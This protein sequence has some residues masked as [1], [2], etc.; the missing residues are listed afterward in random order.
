MINF[1]SDA[2][3]YC[4]AEEMASAY[5]A[6]YF[7]NNTIEFPISPFKMLK[8]ENISWGI[9]FY[10]VAVIRAVMK[11]LFLRQFIGIN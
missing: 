11:Y 4:D 1:Q 2:K 5:L 9:D 10:R 8:D 3:R 7:E 6:A